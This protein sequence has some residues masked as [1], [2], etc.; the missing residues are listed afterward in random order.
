MRLPYLGRG[1]AETVEGVELLSAPFA[2]PRFRVPKDAPSQASNRCPR[3]CGLPQGTGLFYIKEPPRNTRL[4][5]SACPYQPGESN[6][7][8]AQ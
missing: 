6:T 3:Q 2:P 8:L 4:L 1:S 7:W 5:L